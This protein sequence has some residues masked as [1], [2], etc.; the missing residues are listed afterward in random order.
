VKKSQ[1]ERIRKGVGS[2]IGQL[3]LTNPQG[4]VFHP[5]ICPLGNLLVYHWPGFR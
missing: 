2:R 5:G 4:V 1:G 3:S